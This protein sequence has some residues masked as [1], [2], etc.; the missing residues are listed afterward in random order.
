MSL[1]KLSKRLRKYCR[2][3]K[4]ILLIE[5]RLDLPDLPVGYLIYMKRTFDDA[6]KAF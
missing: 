2:T 4:H 3:L 6:V 5:D 1:R